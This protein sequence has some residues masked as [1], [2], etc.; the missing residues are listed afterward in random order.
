MKI[1]ETLQKTFVLSLTCILLLSSCSKQENQPP[2]EIGEVPV[3]LPTTQPEIYTSLEEEPD[4]LPEPTIL[5]TATEQPQKADAIG[6][7][8]IL[9]SSNF[10]YTQSV[11]LGDIDNDG[12]LDLAATSKSGK[13]TWWRNQGGKPVEWE[14]VPVATDF[15]WAHQLT[16]VDIDQ[17]GWLDILG[18]GFS[19]FEISWWRNED[20]QGIEWTKQ[21]IAADYF[22]A[23]EA[24]PADF[25]LD[26]DIDIVGSSG[27]EIT[28]WR[29]DGGNP[30]T[31]HKIS[32]KSGVAF[33]PVRVGD[34]D[35]DGDMD[36]VSG[37][38]SAGEIWWWEN[39]SDEGNAQNLFTEN[40]II[41]NLGSPAGINLGDIDGDGDLD[42]LSADSSN[43]CVML[44]QN[45]GGNPLE[46]SEI[47]IDENFGSAIY[48][49]SADIDN[50]LHLD[51]IASGFSANEVAVWSN[52]D[53]ID[54]AWKKQV[55]AVGLDEVQGI[56]HGDIDGDGDIDLIVAAAGLNDL[57][58]LENE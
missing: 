11:D 45:Q 58:M 7:P 32:L 17:D 51:I 34:L 1:F 35:N 9:I 31:W 41:E 26:G 47:M 21:T 49:T 50:D 16:L 57:I 3:N 42:I 53:G 36:I 33:W 14:K 30:F 24:Y 48:V 39:H 28:W 56:S 18:A 15:P 6:W 37:S 38:D 40:L 8:Q 12:D 43:H 19:A 2:D 46:W 10:K 44:I 25:D 13:I 23:M 27:G 22:Y 29:N 5:P 4:D 52:L 54:T 55:L 20:G